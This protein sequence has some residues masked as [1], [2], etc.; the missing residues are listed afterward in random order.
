MGNL[1]VGFSRPAKGVLPQR[2][3]FKTSLLNR[4]KNG[5]V[6]YLLRIG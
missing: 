2:V 6:V 1:R 5:V 3:K 4:Q